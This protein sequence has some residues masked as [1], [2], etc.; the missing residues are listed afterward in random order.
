M[1][2]A[3]SLEA[4]LGGFEWGEAAAFLLEEIVLEAASIFGGGEDFFPGGDALS[5]EDLVALSGGP[6]LAVHR[7]DAARVGA[8]PGDRIG[9]GCDA[10]ADIELQNDGRL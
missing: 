9:T 4:A 3:E 1:S 2:T 10:G 6:V 5:E 8:D 7:A